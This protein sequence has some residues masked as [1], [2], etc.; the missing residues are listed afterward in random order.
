MADP[1]T[2]AD[3]ITIADAVDN[4]QTLQ[5]EVI[6]EIR[7]VSKVVE[8]LTDAD[9]VHAWDKFAAAAILRAPP[10]EN[11]AELAG[12][13]SEVAGA[14]ISARRAAFADVE[15]SK[16]QGEAGSERTRALIE[17]AQKLE[18]QALASKEERRDLFERAKL[19]RD[20]ADRAL[21]IIPPD[22]IVSPEVKNAAAERR[23]EHANGAS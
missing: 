15:D 16:L 18:A 11:L 19:L 14:L 17:S 6:K 12:F 22:G 5:R 9:E 2:S 10:V 1:T 23:A 3:A 4:L 8:S 13:A 21:G 20:R 7:R